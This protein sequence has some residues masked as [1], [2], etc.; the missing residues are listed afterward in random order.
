MDGWV[1]YH[2]FLKLHDNCVSLPVSCLLTVFTSRGILHVCENRWIIFSARALVSGIHF[3]LDLNITYSG[4]IGLATLPASVP[5]L[6]TARGN[7]LLQLQSAEED[8]AVLPCGQ[9]HH[10]CLLD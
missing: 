4:V 2:R 7:W 8:A 1:G 6:M 10:E 3:E 5:R 9:G